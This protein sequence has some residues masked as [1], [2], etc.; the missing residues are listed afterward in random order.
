M[1][2]V[3]G[4]GLNGGSVRGFCFGLGNCAPGEEALVE[5]LPVGGLVYQKE[6]APETNIPYLKGYMEYKNPTKISTIENKIS[7]AIIEKRKGSAYNAYL[8]CTKVDLRDPGTEPV[9]IGE[10]YDRE[11]KQKSRND[12]NQKPG[13]NSNRTITQHNV[14]N[15]K[16]GKNVLDSKLIDD[17]ESGKYS[18]KE[19]VSLYFVY[20]TKYNNVFHELY[21]LYSPLK[22]TTANVS[23]IDKEN[24]TN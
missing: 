8:N 17:I 3:V 21:D 18:Y 5:N 4:K 6:I 20:F 13:S 14:I 7:R 10:F 22:D 12:K 15:T 2:P 9:I 16:R 23:K 24:F 19:L 11:E 1:C